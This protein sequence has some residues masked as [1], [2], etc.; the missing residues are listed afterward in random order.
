MVP[1]Y[2]AFRVGAALRP[3][4]VLMELPAYSRA[5]M[6]VFAPMSTRIRLSQPENSDHEFGG[7]PSPAESRPERNWSD[8]PDPGAAS[9][10]VTPASNP[11]ANSR[12]PTCFETRSATLSS[13]DSIPGRIAGSTLDRALLPLGLPRVS[14][15]L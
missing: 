10:I 2:P 13:G 8:S 3:A 4:T 14:A 11:V 12:V 15:G 7:A 9:P 5:G 6:G 1:R